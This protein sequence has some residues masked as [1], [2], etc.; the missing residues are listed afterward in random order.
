MFPGHFVFDAAMSS[1]LS[2][3]LELHHAFSSYLRPSDSLALSQ[4]SAATRS[5][6]TSLAYEKCLLIPR[7]QSSRLAGVPSDSEYTII[8]VRVIMNPRKYKWFPYKHVQT[9][10][11][12]DYCIP[13]LLEQHRDDYF[14]LYKRLYYFD[15]LA[16]EK[17]LSDD[18]QH[19]LCYTPLTK[20][21]CSDFAYLIRSVSHLH[22]E[23]FSS[24]FASIL[25]VLKNPKSLKYLEICR[26]ASNIPANIFESISTFSSL[27]SFRIFPTLTWT[28]TE[29]LLLFHQLNSLQNLRSLT[30]VHAIETDSL[31]SLAEFVNPHASHKVVMYKST[32]NNNLFDCLTRQ[33]NV[34]ARLLN[35]LGVD[36]QARIIPIQVNEASTD[37]TISIQPFSN[38][39]NVTNLHVESQSQLSGLI[40]FN[41]PAVREI[42]LRGIENEAA[43]LELFPKIDLLNITSLSL[44]F[45]CFGGAVRAIHHLPKF[46]RLKRFSLEPWSPDVAVVMK[47]RITTCITYNQL[48]LAARLMLHVTGDYFTDTIIEFD[49]VR[50]GLEDDPPFDYQEGY[51]S[52][53]CARFVEVLFSF[54][55]R[56][57]ADQCGMTRQETIEL[58]RDVISNPAMCLVKNCDIFDV[59]LSRADAPSKQDVFSCMKV[60]LA[61]IE[62][63]FKNL[64]TIPTIEYLDFSN[65][66]GVMNSPRLRVIVEAHPTVKQILLHQAT[67]IFPYPSYTQVVKIVQPSDLRR[68]ED[69]NTRSCYLIDAEGRRKKYPDFRRNESHLDYQD[70][71][72]RSFD[73]SN[74]NSRWTVNNGWKNPTCDDFQGWV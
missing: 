51:P 42:T 27:E 58:A 32:A 3:P 66:E 30:T 8:P 9:I 6:Y 69:D 41:F 55:Y 50:T 48:S 45:N 26:E 19:S 12:M 4:S 14:Q 34:F 5:I 2:L 38:C 18:Y 72:F 47:S 16:S 23:I 65:V 29:Y 25:P 68:C 1:F 39:P 56:N 37:D 36:L 67:A 44:S 52:P 17:S 46:Q 57:V 74:T 70:F 43:L 31:Q 54:G 59:Q 64:M 60:L 24:D 35:V 73:H 11:C 53:V 63:V 21:M 61:M 15:V 28:K 7:D 22:L 49:K 10:I 13:R 62:T 33:N 20:K 40:N 71:S